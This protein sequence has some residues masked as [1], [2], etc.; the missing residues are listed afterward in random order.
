[1]KWMEI[2]RTKSGFEVFF[3]MKFQDREKA[4]FWKEL[5]ALRLNIVHE[6]KP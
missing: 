6:P 5:V 2:R 3:V 4:E 1:M